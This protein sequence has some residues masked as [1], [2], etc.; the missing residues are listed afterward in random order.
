MPLLRT[1]VSAFWQKVQFNIC[2]SP[3]RLKL[4]YTLLVYALHIAYSDV[5]LMVIRLCSSFIF[6]VFL[7]IYSY[8]LL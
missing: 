7:C 5:L 8:T 2:E 6:C 1:A 4:Y 3:N